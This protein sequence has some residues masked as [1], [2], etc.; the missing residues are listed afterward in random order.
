M[1]CLNLVHYAD[2]KAVIA[3]HESNPVTQMENVKGYYAGEECQRMGN[4]Q[5]KQRKAPTADVQFNYNRTCRQLHIFYCKSS[6]KTSLRIGLSGLPVRSAPRIGL[7]V[8]HL[9]KIS[10]SFRFFFVFRYVIP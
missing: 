9:S 5:I 10:F 4:R 6:L 1:P 8:A 7:P 3:R 2:I